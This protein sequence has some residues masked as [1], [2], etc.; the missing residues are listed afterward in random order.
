MAALVAFMSVV[1]ISKFSRSRIHVQEAL[2]LLSSQIRI[3]QTEAVSS[4]KRNNYIPCGYGV[5]YI[6]ATH[7]TLYA[8]PNAATTTCQS[9]NRNYQALEDTLISTP[10]FQDS[11]V[12]FKSSFADVFFEPPDPKTYID[13]NA[14]LNQGPVII[15]IGVAG[16]AC[17]TDCKSLYIYPSGKIDVQ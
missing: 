2:A 17:P 13:N 3:A 5:H 9:I 8:G 11:Q 12:Q 14:S 16:T 7:F 4:A 10:R 6:D 15:T 1:L